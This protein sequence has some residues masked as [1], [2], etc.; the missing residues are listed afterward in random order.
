MPFSSFHLP[1]PV[2]KAIHDLGYKAPTAIQQQAIPLLIA[3]KDVIGQSETG[4]GKTAA[5]GLPLLRMLSPG[6]GIQGLILTPTRE[7]CVQVSDSLKGFAKYLQAKIV[8]VFG[9]VGIGEQLHALRSADIVVATPGRLLDVMGRGVRLSS[10]R[11]LV[12]DEADRMLDM[13]F[14]DDVEKIIRETPKQR[15]TVLFSATL[16]SKLRSLV[17]RHM[18]SPASVQT[19]TQVDTSLLSETGYV[20]QPQDKFSLLVHFLKHET[21]GIVLVFCATRRSC[22]KIAKNLRVQ[23]IP[24]IEIHGGL[25]QSKRMQTIATLHKRGVGVLVATD[26]A[27]RGLHINNISHVYN[28]D[29]PQT[30]DDYVHRIGRTARAGAKGKA[31]TFVT[32]HESKEFGFIL[33][34]LRHDVSPSPLPV[35]EKVAFATGSTHDHSHQG[36]D[37]GRTFWKK[38]QR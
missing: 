27:S 2:A 7:L 13:G 25:S 6:K 11:Y 24:A 29:L 31:I 12:L 34:T 33:R 20:V 36:K 37:R 1:A 21:S 4:S 32:S 22:D 38:R 15:Q 30:P 5:F 26:V 8:P 3:G 14:I 28:Y 18:N 10:V 17:N 23:K 19:K 16:S 9:G 35:F